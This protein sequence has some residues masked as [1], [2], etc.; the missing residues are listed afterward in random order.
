M[1]LVNKW[2]D[3]AANHNSDRVFSFCF[4]LLLGLKLKQC[5]PVDM[6]IES[7]AHFDWIFSS[8]KAESLILQL[9]KPFQL[10]L[11][12][13]KTLFKHKTKKKAMPGICLLRKNR[14][15]ANMTCCSCWGSWIQAI[16][17]V[18]L[19]LES[20]ESTQREITI[21]IVLELFIFQYSDI[22]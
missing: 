18:V 12:A 16:N 8:Q 20:L 6:K 7:I 10:F 2:R 4:A 19:L 15:W 9:K 11:C 14:H 1:H 22:H 13:T 5:V 3:Q 17:L 21:T